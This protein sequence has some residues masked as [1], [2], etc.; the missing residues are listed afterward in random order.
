MNVIGTVMTSSPGPTPAADQ[1]QVQGRGPGV[2]ADAVPG[3]DVSGEG[4]LERGDL[5]PEH[6]RRAVG[7]LVR[8]PR[9]TSSR[10]LVVLGAQVQEG[11]GR[12]A[13]G[14]GSVPA[15][16]ARPLRAVSLIGLE[17]M[18]TVRTCA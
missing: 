8:G 12:F 2:D 13:P 15:P 6:V 3:T 9:S 10:E 5:R 14:P 16:P 11:D 7:H 4:L 17:L 1:G 18:V